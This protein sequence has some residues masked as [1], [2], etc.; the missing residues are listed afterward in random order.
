[1]KKQGAD[2]PDTLGT[3][4]NLASAYQDA[5]K[6]REAIALFEQVRDAVVKKLGADHPNSLGTLN[7]LA[8][9]YRAA[10]RLR[11]AIALY[12][13]LHDAVVKKLGGDHP[14]AL[15]TLNGLATAYCAA[16]K[17]PKSIALFEQVRDARVK[18]LGADHPVTL[19]TVY[20]L[21]SAYHAAGKVPEAISLFEQ[22]RDAQMKK[23]GAD[24][25]DT[26]TT[27]GSLAR[28]Y[29]E[30]GKPNQA[31]PLF[32]QA[33]RGI[34]KRRFQHEYAGGIMART[35]AAYEQAEHFDQAETW[36]RKWL[37]VVK[38]RAGAHSPAYASELAGLGANLLQHEKWTDAEATLKECLAIRQKNQPDD[39]TTFSTLSMLG[40]ALLGQKKHAAAEPLLVKGFEGMKERN[41]TIP[42]GGRPRLREAADRLITLYEAQGKPEEAAK[43]R[44]QRQ[45]LQQSAAPKGADKK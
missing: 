31:L 27:L 9:A 34:E 26:L 38:Q 20:N 3:L 10:G 8:G 45:A 42:P 35:I 33:A 28:V 40:G 1:V 2:H 23:L 5:G 6:L 19:T 11:E 14:H 44:Q 18:K 17:L 29:Q 30:A 4:N 22:L 16:G 21:A 15:T 25:P 41:Q 32:A 13:Q 37:A 24:H 36:R 39:W 43:W 12:E 7:N